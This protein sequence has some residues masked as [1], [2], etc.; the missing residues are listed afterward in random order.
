MTDNGLAALAEALETVMRDSVARV[1]G[2]YAALGS[3]EVT[4]TFD[5]P[6]FAAAILGERGV[7]WPTGL[8]EYRELI[9]QYQATIATAAAR[10]EHDAT[11]IARLNMEIATLDANLLGYLE[12]LDKTEKERDTL[13]ADNKLLTVERDLA[14][15]ERDPL[16]AALDDLA[17]ILPADRWHLVR[18]TTTVA[19]ATAKE[20]GR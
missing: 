4:I 16:R 10:I 7:F 19:L 5:R 2:P 3:P 11:E 18:P 13:R 9:H 15:Q 6:A 20:A 12:I 1:G 8:E 17:A 14:Q